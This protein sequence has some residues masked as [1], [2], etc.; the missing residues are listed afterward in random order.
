MTLDTFID[1]KY[2]EQFKFTVD[3]EEYKGYYR[4][5]TKNFLKPMQI[6]E[7]SGTKKYEPGDSSGVF[8]QLAETP[9]YKQ[10]LA[11]SLS[12]LKQTTINQSLQQEAVQYANESGQLEVWNAVVPTSEL[13]GDA[14]PNAPLPDPLSKEK[15]APGPSFNPTPVVSIAPALPNFDKA[16]ALRYPL[17]AYNTSEFTQDHMIIEMFSYNPPQSNLFGPSNFGETL[18][19]GLSRNTNLKD[20]RGL[21]KLPI[22]NQLA[23]TNGV[24]W[25]A[26]SA[27]AFTAAAFGSAA[28]SAQALLGGNFFGAVNQVGQDLLGGA[29]ALLGNAGK[30]TATGT[31]LTALAAKYGLGKLGINVDPN[32]FIARAS[33]NAI[34]PNLELLFNGPKLRDFE[35]NFEFAPNSKDEAKEVRRIMRFFRRGMMPRRGDDGNLIFLGSPDVFRLRY[36]TGDQRIR[37]LNTFKIC[38]LTEC[39]I[40]FAPQG[41]YQSYNDPDAGSQPVLSTMTL[42]FTELTPIFAED[43]DQ[44]ADDP[45]IQDLLFDRG[46]ELGGIDQLD[47]NDIGF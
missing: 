31:L 20:F 16:E 43:Y 34:N 42:N 6:N 17:D 32:Q 29:E 1:N 47:E 27:N 9:E 28:K 45:S 40:D 37:G 4:I 30:G 13:S 10:A 8:E 23:F 39:T 25:G 11:T 41:E 33:G 15:K 36:R 22:P 5:G 35:F 2:F 46:S 38:A 24:N 44:T 3:G 21:V 7:V 18:T 14:D 19:T 12:E 26:D